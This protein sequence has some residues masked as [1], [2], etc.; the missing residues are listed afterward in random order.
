MDDGLRM[1]FLNSGH[2]WPRH[3]WKSMRSTWSTRSCHVLLF[4]LKRVVDPSGRKHVPL[5]HAR[6]ERP[7]QFKAEGWEI[8]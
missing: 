6:V 5:C 8:H 7:A 1:T 2:P 4:G 3:T